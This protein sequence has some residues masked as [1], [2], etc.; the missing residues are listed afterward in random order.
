ME[1]RLRL[2]SVDKQKL[3]DLLDESGDKLLELENELAESVARLTKTC[4]EF[5]ELKD[6]NNWLLNEFEGIIQ[7]NER[8]ANALASEL[9]ASSATASELVN[10]LLSGSS[11]LPR[12]ELVSRLKE[13]RRKQRFNLK[14]GELMHL[15]S[16]SSSSPAASRQRGSRRRRKL[17]NTSSASSPELDESDEAEAEDGDEGRLRHEAA[18]EIFAMLR[19][20]R[21]ELQH[22]K[23][24]LVSNAHQ[25]H[26]FTATSADDSGI[27][28]DEGE[29]TQMRF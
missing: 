11:S 1:R 3:S 21:F 7:M 17:R 5:N 4:D 6:A 24:T 2:A 15:S 29:E 13:L 12:S 10:K 18:C 14:A 23:E 20:F 22:R 8:V 25:Q 27:S 26:K 9:G 16:S 19:K 28:A